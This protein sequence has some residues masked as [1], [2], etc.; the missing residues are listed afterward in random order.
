[1]KYAIVVNNSD[2]AEVSITL[3]MTLREWKYVQRDMKGGNIPARDVM[4]TITGAIQQ[5]TINLE[6]ENGGAL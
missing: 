1:M 6:G 3:T 5:V 2:D 4:D